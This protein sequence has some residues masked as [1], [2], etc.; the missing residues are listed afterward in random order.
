M[1]P[2]S[3]RRLLWNKKALG[4]PVGN[5]IILIAAVALSTTVVLYAVNIT[6]NQVQ[7]ESLYISSATLTTDKAEIGISNTGPTSIRVTQLTIKGDKFSNYTSNPEI[8]TGLSKGNSTTLTVTLTDGLV[9][10]DDVGRPITIVI[11]TTQCTY[12]IET[13]VQASAETPP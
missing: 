6:S 13:L 8:G 11:S 10:L 12:F 2:L 4:A 5:L 9:T 3:L 7:K 1:R